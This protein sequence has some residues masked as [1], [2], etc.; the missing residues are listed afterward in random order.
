MGLPQVVSGKESA[1]S[2]GDA[3]DM[4]LI[5]G[6]GRF[7]GGGNGNPILCPVRILDRGALQTTVHE[8]AEMD[9]TEQLSMHS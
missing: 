3:R 8:V 6:L 7:L 4:D 9:T 5:P 2:S 1:C